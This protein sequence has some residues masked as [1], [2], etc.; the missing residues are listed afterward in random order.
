MTTTQQSIITLLKSAITGEPYPL[1]DD[2][3]LAAIYPQVKKHHMDALLYEG[4]VRCG[5]PRKDPVMQELFQRYCR[6]LLVSEGQMGEV[7][8][9][10]AAFDA[11]GIDYLPLKGVNMKPRYPKPELRS[12]GD[13]DIL[14]RTEQ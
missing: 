13:A 2:F 14:I 3:D 9:I 11:A 7:A 6:S 1:P 12:M 10:F 8:R 5:I 4:A